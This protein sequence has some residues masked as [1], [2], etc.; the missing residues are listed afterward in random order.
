M[1]F[2]PEIEGGSFGE[3]VNNLR[4]TMF[5]VCQGSCLCGTV[6]NRGKVIYCYGDLV[7]RHGELFSETT[8]NNNK[9]SPRDLLA[10][11]LGIWVFG[12]I[13]L[14]VVLL[15]IRKSISSL[16]QHIEKVTERL[17]W[18]H[19]DDDL[20]SNNS[21]ATSPHIHGKDTT[22]ESMEG[23]PPSDYDDMLTPD[24]DRLDSPPLALNLRGTS[25]AKGS[26]QG[27]NL[28]TLRV[29]RKD[30]KKAGDGLRGKNVTEA[31]RVK[32]KDMKRTMK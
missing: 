26:S 23:L 25:A 7:P 21:T 14:L 2:P 30:Y 22:L 3:H 9:A 16:R 15:L 19:D 17:P 12:L 8:N 18:Y 29:G 4:G 1:Q 28:R 5:Y 13:A 20:L 6:N 24:T 31:F 27:S 10:A 32:E 11:Q